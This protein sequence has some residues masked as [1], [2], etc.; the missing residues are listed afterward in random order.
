MKFGKKVKIPRLPPKVDW[1]DVT[2]D[3]QNPALD[4][5]GSQRQR[6]TQKMKEIES[7]W[8]LESI[9]QKRLS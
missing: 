3:L 2:I 8:P 6:L 4:K 9:A 7:Q 5:N 1:A